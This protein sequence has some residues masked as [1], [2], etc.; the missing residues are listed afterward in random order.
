M[1]T[2]RILALALL[3][4]LSSSGTLQ[5][6]LGKI[7]DPVSYT[8]PLGEDLTFVM[9]GDA[10][11]EAKTEEAERFR[12]LRA[13]YPT[14]GLYRGT[15]RIWELNGPFAPADGVFLSSDGT[16]LVRLDGEWWREKYFAGSKRLPKDKEDRQ[17]DAVA[18]S[19][20][21]NGELLK[22]HTL[23]SL[24]T[25]ADKLPHSPEYV[26]WVAGAVMNEDSGKFVLFIQDS[27][28]WTFDYRTG[29]VLSHEEAG[30][31]NPIFQQILIG[32]A[33]TAVLVLLVW[34]WLAFV[35]WQQVPEG[36]TS[37]S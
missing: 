9:L 15:E 37:E 12:E 8:K 18:V 5:A 7:P 28:R 23:R 36:S 24:V 20:F 26:L 2:L 25:N 6:A 16:Y 34:A 4:I 33:A 29:E 10:A 22:N 14:S 31:G 1:N 13:K 35:R 30:L 11:N 27:V 32:V 21:K 17:L 3:S 19:F